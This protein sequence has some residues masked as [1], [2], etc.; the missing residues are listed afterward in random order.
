MQLIQDTAALAGVLPSRT[1][2]PRTRGYT[3]MALAVATPDGI[4]DEHGEVHTD[5]IH[6]VKHALPTAFVTID[7]SSFLSSLD[8]YYRGH[9]HWRFTLARIVAERGSLSISRVK[10]TTFGFRACKT[11]TERAAC[12]L[13]CG[14]LSARK[15]RLHQC[16]DP[17]AMSPTP[18]HKLISDVSVPSLLHWAT[19]VR[20]WA[21]TQDLELRAA[22]A[23]YGAQLLRDPRFYPEPRRRVPRATNEHVRPSLPGNLVRLVNTTPGPRTYNVTS[24]D[25]RSAHHRIAQEIALPDAN[26]L[27]ARGYFGDPESA[28]RLWA[29]RGSALY[30]RTIRQPGLVYVLATSRLTAPGQFRLQLQNFTGQQRIYLWTNTVDFIE[31]TGTRIDGIYAAWT[32]TSTDAGLSRYGSWAQNQIENASH[33]RKQWLKPL[34]H[35]TYGLLAARARPLQLGTNHGTAG[36]SSHFLLGPRSFPVTVRELTNFQPAFVNVAQRGMIEAETQLRS[37]RMAQYLTDA[38]CIVTHIHTDGLHVEGKLPLLPDTWGINGLTDVTYIDNVS[39]IA[40]ERECLPGRDT[41][42]RMEL[43]KHHARLLVTGTETQRRINPH[44]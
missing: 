15:G 32:S 7:P 42:E 20:E 14:G 26:T 13:C 18:V 8:D 22:L 43:V 29:P 21:R 41:R 9:P 6:Y 1:V 16:W 27:F 39:W 17:R 3:H 30:E 36:K 4:I 12:P 31:S 37:L 5:P 38:D 34:L 28:P 25:Q 2:K 35:S 19:D 24:I 23:G 33:G 11:P 40:R 10:L 44:G